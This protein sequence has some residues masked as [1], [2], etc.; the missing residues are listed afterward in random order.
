MLVQRDRSFDG[1]NPRTHKGC[2]PQ[3]PVS[4]TLRCGFNP[5]THKG[6]DSSNSIQ[7]FTRTGFQSTHP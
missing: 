2:D 3:Q 6:C 5:R 4:Q 1:F 7:Y